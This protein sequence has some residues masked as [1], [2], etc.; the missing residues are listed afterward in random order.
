MG[1]MNP[2]FIPAAHQASTIATRATSFQRTNLERLER[3][4]TLIQLPRLKYIPVTP[5]L[6]QRRGSI[7]KGNRFPHRE[8]V[9]GNN[10]DH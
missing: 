2:S 1:T 10:G 6:S 8:R 5:S 7:I 3:L 4:M 9:T